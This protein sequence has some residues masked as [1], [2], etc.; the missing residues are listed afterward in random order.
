MIDF[1]QTLQKRPKKFKGN[2]GANEKAIKNTR[3][4]KSAQTKNDCKR[5]RYK[6][7]YMIGNNIQ[8]LEYDEKHAGLKQNKEVLDKHFRALKKGMNKTRDLDRE[9]LTKLT[10]KSDECIKK[11]EKVEKVAA[12]ILKVSSPKLFRLN[13]TGFLLEL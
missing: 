4:H 10:L 6:F 5:Q 8:L 7:I 2:R 12:D 11:C 9:K 3:Q 13:L 1:D